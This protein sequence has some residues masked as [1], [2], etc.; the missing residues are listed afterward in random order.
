MKEHSYTIVLEPADE[1]GYTVTV[2]AIPAI[3]TEGDTF[4][5]AIEMARDAIA[6]YLSS[7]AKKGRSFPVEDAPA[8]RTT[9]RIQVE[10]PAAS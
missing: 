8:G 6:C 9:V 2:P 10:T 4:D 7:L 1:G 3:V 5:E